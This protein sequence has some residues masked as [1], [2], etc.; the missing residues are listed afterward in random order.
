MAK[1]QY[2]SEI[3]QTAKKIQIKNMNYVKTYITQSLFLLIAVKRLYITYTHLF[4]QINLNAN[5][6]SRNNL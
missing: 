1:E 6:A 5:I 4:T 2:P 3:T